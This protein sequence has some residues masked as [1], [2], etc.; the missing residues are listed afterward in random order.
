MFFLKMGKD[1]ILTLPQELNLSGK[2]FL[3]RK[4]GERLIIEPIRPNCLLA[5]LEALAD[6]DEAFPD[7]DQN[8]LPLD[9]VVL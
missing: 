6:I 1:H 2:E 5:V 3:L 8:L 7:V 4:E 9:E